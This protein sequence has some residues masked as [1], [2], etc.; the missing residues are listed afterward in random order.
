MLKHV[1]DILTDMGEGRLQHRTATHTYQKHISK[2]KSTQRGNTPQN[3]HIHVP[4]MAAD[5]IYT[6]Y[7]KK[8]R[9]HTD[10]HG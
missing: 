10:I 8:C 4:K 9:R 3:K 7:V 2:N 5:K 6:V 1:E